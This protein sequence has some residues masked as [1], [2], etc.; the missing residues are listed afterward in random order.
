MIV[1]NNILLIC[2]QNSLSNLLQTFESESQCEKTLLLD[3]EDWKEDY[4]SCGGKNQSPISIYLK[5]TRYLRTNEL[6][7]SGYSTTAS[8]LTMTNTGYTGDSVVVVAIVVMD[9]VMFIVTV[10]VVVVVVVRNG[11]GS[12][13][14]ESFSEYRKLICGHPFL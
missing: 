7:F 10:V 3:N 4:P 11:T 5:D 2:I 12:A 13:L 8:N 9:D 1:L 14:L 6:I